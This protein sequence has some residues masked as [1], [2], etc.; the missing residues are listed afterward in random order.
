MTSLPM[1]IRETEMEAIEIVA[2]NV[3]E[4]TAKAAAQLGV[5]KSQLNITVLEETKGLFGK[6]Q[7]RIRAEAN[8]VA[9]KAEEAKPEKAEKKPRVAKKAPEKPAPKVIDKAVVDAEVAPAPADKPSEVVA[10]TEDADKVIAVLNDLLSESGLQV[11][12]EVAGM[13]GKYINL[14]LGGRDVSYLVG[15]RG[16]VLNAVQ[17]LM[18]VIVAR[19]LETGVRVVIDGDNFRRR[20]EEVLEKLAHDIATEVQKRGEEAVLDALPAFERRVI[21]QALQEFPGVVTYS[22]GEEPDRRVVIAPAEAP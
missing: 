19:Q 8:A 10:T 21:H 15:R 7:V 5:D 2:G 6:G 3:S 9:D 18:N 22:E 17:Y 4:A 20:R 14:S 1:G 16:E 11:S 13:R 12:I